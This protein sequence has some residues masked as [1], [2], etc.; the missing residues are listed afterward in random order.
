MPLGLGLI[1]LACILALSS[2]GV[3]VLPHLQGDQICESYPVAAD[4]ISFWPPGYSCVADSGRVL[5][6]KHEVAGFFAVFGAVLALALGVARSVPRPPAWL[7]GA[8]SGAVTVA[9]TGLCILWISAFVPVFVYGVFWSVPVAWFVEWRLIGPTGGA[10]R[11][12]RGAV[13]AG[14]SFVFLGFGLLLGI[15]LAAPLVA[16][17]AA[18]SL[19]HLAERPKRLPS[20]A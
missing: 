7:R 20:P 6:E 18:A 10:L 2:V 9:L 15:E 19:G 4:D 8:V 11:A 13:L 5:E 16:V 14:V 12:A 1:L 3:V 17:L